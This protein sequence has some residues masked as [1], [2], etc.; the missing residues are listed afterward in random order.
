[1]PTLLTDLPEITS[2]TDDDAIFHLRLSNGRDVKI[3]YSDLKTT[4]GA[5]AGSEWLSTKTYPY[6]SIVTHQK[7][8]YIARRNV[9][10]G[11]APYFNNNKDW[12]IK[13]KYDALAAMPIGTIIWTDD[14]TTK[15]SPGEN[16]WCGQWASLQSSVYGQM[17]QNPSANETT[18]VDS[19]IYFYWNSNDMLQVDE[20]INQ[21]NAY[22]LKTIT[23]NELGATSLAHTNYGGYSIPQSFQNFT[24][25]NSNLHFRPR[26]RTACAYRLEGY[27]DL[28]SS[29]TN[30]KG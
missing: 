3:K 28:I 10:A 12:L 19:Q 26:S 16:L 13:Y 17:W 30:G 8:T 2:I 15:K 22:G 27:G 23:K 29:I 21:I 7:S 4:I 1:M 20:T 5:D 11:I 18:G 24:P 9:A 25:N 14:Y 6:G